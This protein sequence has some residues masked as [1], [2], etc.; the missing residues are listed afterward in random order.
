M[1]YLP[2]FIPAL[3]ETQNE[4]AINFAK[5][6]Q[7]LQPPHEE[8][9][10]LAREI[11]ESEGCPERRE[12]EHWLQAEFQLLAYRIH[13]WLAENEEDSPLLERSVVDRKNIDIPD[14]PGR[15]K[16]VLADSPLR[17]WGVDN[18]DVDIYSLG[19]D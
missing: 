2:I 5:L 11:Y 15:R 9:E 16:G 18:T 6:L 19:A 10:E 17:S 3:L 14:V 1:N 8:I 13:E 7:R 4:V 12:L